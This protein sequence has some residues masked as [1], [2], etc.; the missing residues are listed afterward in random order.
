MNSVFESG[1]SLPAVYKLNVNIELMHILVILIIF[2]LIV[3]CSWHKKNTLECLTE[4]L[5]RDCKKKTKSKSSPSQTQNQSAG[6][7]IYGR[8][9]KNKIKPREKSP[10]HLTGNY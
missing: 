6:N 10:G 4:M 9:Q 5:N 7:V 8:I 3:H 1:S 2:S